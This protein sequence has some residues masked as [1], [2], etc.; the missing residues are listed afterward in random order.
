MEE[1]P[2]KQCTLS[3]NGIFLNLSIVSGLIG[4]DPVG[5]VAGAGG[6]PSTFVLAAHWQQAN[7]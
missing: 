5:M 4:D 6:G 2:F 7:K 3:I 1:V